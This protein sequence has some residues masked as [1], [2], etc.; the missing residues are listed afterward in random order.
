MSCLTL[1]QETSCLLGRNA[2]T[3]MEMAGQNARED[4]SVC[5][6]KLIWTELNNWDQTEGIERE[7]GNIL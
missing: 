1:S 5:Q 6:M 2:A 4:R 7:I 3:R